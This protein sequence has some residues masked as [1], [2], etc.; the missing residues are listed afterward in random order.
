MP[1]QGA[2][3]ITDKAV[4]A[5]ILKT[6]PLNS[7]D[8]PPVAVVTM[9]PLSGHRP[10]STTFVMCTRQEGSYIARTMH[11]YPLSRTPPQ[12]ILRSTNLGATPQMMRAVLEV[13]RDASDHHTWQKTP[14]Q[15]ARKWLTQ[16]NIVATSVTAARDCKNTTRLLTRLFVQVH[17][18]TDLRR[19]SGIDGVLIRPQAASRE[20]VVWLKPEHSLKEARDAAQLYHGRVIASPKSFGLVITDP[21]QE[22]R[23]CAAIHG[24]A[25]LADQKSLLMRG[26]PKDTNPAD[27]VAA[28]NNHGLSCTAQAVQSTGK[29]W[30]VKVT[31]RQSVPDD[32][33]VINGKPVI[34]CEAQPGHRFKNRRKRKRS[35]SGP[36]TPDAKPEAK[37]QRKPRK[38]KTATKKKK[39]TQP[40]TPPQRQSR[41]LSRGR[42]YRSRTSL[43]CNSWWR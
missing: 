16:A 24:D 5:D 23:A 27:F 20:R 6:H 7:R 18:D 22:R 29:T 10:H 14:A 30:C 39:K 11:V 32:P 1:E 41:S 25:G 31:T 43:Y 35:G 2:V 34:A 15:A 40:P 17:P 19:A 37:R 38:K 9:E 8:G 33:C 3:A 42:S 12:H 21:D 26:V 13:T 36:D 4:A 28:L